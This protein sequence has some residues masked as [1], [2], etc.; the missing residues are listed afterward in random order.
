[1]GQDNVTPVELLNS[2]KGKLH[3]EYVSFQ[4]MGRGW[5]P[6]DEERVSTIVHAIGLIDKTLRVLGE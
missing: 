5:L 4:I 1:M 3:S 6:E 2:A